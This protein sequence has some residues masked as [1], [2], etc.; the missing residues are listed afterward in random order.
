[1]HVCFVNTLLWRLKTQTFSTEVMNY[2]QSLF[3]SF[4]PSCLMF[5]LFILKAKQKQKQ[6]WSSSVY[7]FTSVQFMHL[8]GS[9]HC[10]WHAERLLI[11]SLCMLAKCVR[12]YSKFTST[13]CIFFTSKPP[14]VLVACADWTCSSVWCGPFY[15]A[16]GA[17]GAVTERLWGETTT[18]TA[19]Q[20][21]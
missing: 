18:N 6:V 7:H 2:C 3:I 9:A 15:A 8:Y 11:T 10:Q 13:C 20:S 14:S 4:Y 19:L 12:H 16:R 5:V 17:G 1:M 21:E